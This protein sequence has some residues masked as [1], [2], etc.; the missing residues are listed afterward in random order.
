ML[1]LHIK[2]SQVGTIIRLVTYINAGKGCNEEMCV[3]GFKL[4]MH[5]LNYMNSNIIAK[6]HKSRKS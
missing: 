3:I 5:I 2:L 6:K 1:N 4:I